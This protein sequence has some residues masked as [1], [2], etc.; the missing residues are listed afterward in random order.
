MVVLFNYQQGARLLLRRGGQAA[1]DQ[2]SFFKTLIKNELLS[3]VAAQ[4]GSRKTALCRH[5]AGRCPRTGHRAKM[6]YSPFQRGGRERGRVIGVIMA[7][8]GKGRV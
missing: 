2:A 4:Q 8:R 7:E 1:M 6:V 5:G 3:S